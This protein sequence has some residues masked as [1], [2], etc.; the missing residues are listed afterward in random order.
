MLGVAVPAASIDAFGS[1]FRAGLT[2]QLSAGGCEVPPTMQ[3]GFAVDDPA[4]PVL[5]ATVSFGCDDSAGGVRYAV[6]LGGSDSAGWTITSATREDLCL[7]GTSG[8]LC[9]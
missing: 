6:T 1:A 9:V 2:V 7:R 3:L 8:A 5:H 4:A